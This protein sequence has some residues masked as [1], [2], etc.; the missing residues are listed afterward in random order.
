MPRCRPAPHRGMRSSIDGRSHGRYRS[1]RRCGHFASDPVWLRMLEHQPTARLR[2]RP[3]RWDIL[4]PREGPAGTAAPP[5][6]SKVNDLPSAPRHKSSRPS[7][8]ALTGADH[9]ALAP[10]PS[11]STGY[12]RGPNSPWTAP[13]RRPLPGH[14]ILA[15]S[16]AEPS[17]KPYSNRFALCGYPSTG[18]CREWQQLDGA[19][20]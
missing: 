2:T 5:V 11:R 19:L 8:K 3:P 6:I 14:A 9:P 20:G 12:G 7:V 4:I 16:P 17:P 13:R 18:M 1:A 10:S 15:R